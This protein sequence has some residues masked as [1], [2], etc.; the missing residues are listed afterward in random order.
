MGKTQLHLLHLIGLDAIDEALHL[1]TDATEELISLLACLTCD[2][3]LFLD[4]L[5]Q[6]VVGNEELVL[7]FLLD[8]VLAEEF[9]KALGDLAFHEL[10]N[11]LHGVL[12]VLELGESLQL[13]DLV[14]RFAI[15]E[16]LVELVQLFEL[17]V[18]CDFEKGE[19][20]GCLE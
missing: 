1:E 19:A 11:G 14:G 18:L 13:D 8:N 6:L 12:G 2:A 9:L 15:H 20:S 7:D 16:T 4:V 5:A 3:E 10:L 17:L